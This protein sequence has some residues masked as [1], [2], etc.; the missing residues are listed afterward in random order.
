MSTWLTP[1]ARWYFSRFPLDKGKW[2]MWRRFMR[3]PAYRRFQP[4]AHETA[5]GFR[6]WLDPSENID[7]FIFY[8]GAWEPDEAWLIYRLLRQGDVF[9]DVGANEGFHTLVGSSRVGPSGQVVAFEP[10]PPTIERLHRNIQLNGLQNIAVVEAACVEAPREIKLSRQANERSS[11]VYSMRSEG[12]ESWSVAGVRMDDALRPF[13]RKVRL[14]KMDIEGAE[15]LAL[16]G[17]TDCLRQADAPLLLCE[18][19]D[20]FLKTMGESARGL[21]AFMA[22]FG[23]R[24][25]RLQRRVLLPVDVGWA[26]DQFQLNVL[27]AKDGSVDDLLV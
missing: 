26:A 14:V 25:Y 12:A 16:Q 11:G 27:F 13:R 4:G 7:R 8:W 3:H 1:L 19:T 21:Y 17:F 5:Y 24:P 20:S 10:V 2:S 15:L 18:V 22:G 6:M 23:Y 9:V